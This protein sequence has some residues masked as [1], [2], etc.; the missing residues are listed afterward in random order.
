[1]NRSRIVECSVC[2][3]R[4]YVVEEDETYDKYLEHLRSHD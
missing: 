2:G 4:F 1:M 3:V